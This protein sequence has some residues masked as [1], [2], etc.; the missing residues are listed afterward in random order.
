MFSDASDNKAGPT[1]PGALLAKMSKTERM[2]EYASQQRVAAK[3]KGRRLPA[4]AP[5]DH[6][7][8]QRKLASIIQS[9]DKYTY[10]SNSTL[11]N[12]IKGM[13]AKVQSEQDSDDE[14]TKMIRSLPSFKTG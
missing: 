2:R 1:V 12:S 13:K 10:G 11:A 4:I 5:V 3:A 9:T 14:H 7:A 8:A 6:D